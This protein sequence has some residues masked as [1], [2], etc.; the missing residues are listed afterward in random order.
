MAKKNYVYITER[1]LDTGCTNILEVFSSYEKA[2][3]FVIDQANQS[4]INIEDKVFAD[5]DYEVDGERFTISVKWNK[6]RDE[7]DWDG[8]DFRRRF[9]VYRRELIK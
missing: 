4:M 6:E 2:K 3:D 8:P 7:Y 5:V 9:Y 1:E